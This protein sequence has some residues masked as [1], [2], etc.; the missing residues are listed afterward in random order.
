MDKKRI[1]DYFSNSNNIYHGHGIGNVKK[2]ETLSEEIMKSIFENGLRT[3]NA[4]M[5]WTTKGLGKGSETLFD[6]QIENFENWGHS[7]TKI[8][9]VSLPEEY[10]IFNRNLA[11]ESISPAAFYKFMTEEEA[12]KLGL[13]QGAYVMPEFVVGMYD[14]VTRSFIENDMYYEKL[15]IEK[16]KELF[17]KIKDNYIQEIRASGLTLEQHKEIMEEM[18]YKSPL[19]EEEIMDAVKIPQRETV[20]ERA[21]RDKE[22]V[23]KKIKEVSGETSPSIFDE[24]G[25]IIIQKYINPTLMKKKLRYP[26]G[27]EVSALQYIQ[28]YVVPHIPESGTF[29]LKNGQVISARQFIEEYIFFDGQDKYNGDIEELMKNALATDDKDGQG[30]GLKQEYGI[31]ADEE[32][33]EVD[34]KSNSNSFADSLLT[35]PR[36]KISSSSF[37]ESLASLRKKDMTSRSS[38]TKSFGKIKARTTGEKSKESKKQ[39]NGQSL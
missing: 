38:M 14:S 23:E 11:N 7:S 24:N 36:G 32:T 5:F 28:E 6:E 25:N 20:I 34:E 31:V 37:N 19:T 10:Y 22:I 33:I 15:S 1:E 26:N 17:N 2:G 18:G 16:Q 8:I 35:K 4:Q 9:I 39:Y 27:R 30:V 21:L 12:T 3:N 29:T 13:S